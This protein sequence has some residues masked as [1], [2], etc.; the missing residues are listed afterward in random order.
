MTVA[1]AVSDLAPGLLDHVLAVVLKEADP[2]LC[3]S[4][5]LDVRT[6]GC[7]L[8]DDSFVHD[9]GV[10]EELAEQSSI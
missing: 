6:Q 3:E 8:H 4:R 7:K 1:E 5:E 9:R 2:D 10:H